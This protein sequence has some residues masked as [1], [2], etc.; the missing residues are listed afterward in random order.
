MIPNDH[1]GNSAPGFI[2]YTIKAGHQYAD[3]SNYKQTDYNELR[4][5]V[6]FDSTSIYQTASSANQL[7]VNKLYGFSDNSDDHHRFSAR[8]GW[9]WS[10]GALQ[11][12][13]YTYNDGVMSYEALGSIRIG[14]EYTCSI[15][16]TASA[17]LFSVNEGVKT[18]PRT[19][20]TATAIGYRL[21]PYF[22]GDEAAPH[23]INI[24]IKEM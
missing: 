9:R 24:W 6:R 22:G 19:S 20:T 14:T 3:Q 23:D 12:F 18:M 5:I 2:K 13:A 10:E 1:T 17:Y 7:D 16:I 8:F 4:F 21:Y 15:K 11:L